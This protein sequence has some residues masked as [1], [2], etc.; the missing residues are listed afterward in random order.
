MR[1]PASRHSRVEEVLVFAADKQ[2]RSP[3]EAA[4]PE[5][6][7]WFDTHSLPVPRLPP[8][9]LAADASRIQAVMLAL[10]DGKRSI[11]E[12]TKII[13]EQGLLPGD[14]AR[15]AVRGLLERLYVAGER[16]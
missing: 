14:Q 11:D 10:V 12:L 5:L 13:S 1:S 3:H 4:P 2:R 7:Q 15:S 9:A 8:L 6:P 16:S